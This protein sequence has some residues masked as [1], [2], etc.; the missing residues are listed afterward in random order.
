MLTPALDFLTA[1]E[2][3]PAELVEHA[4]RNDCHTIGLLVQ[5]VQRFPFPDGKL[6]G[7]TAERRQL[8]RTCRDLDVTIDTIEVFI[9]D[10]GCKP[11]LFRPAIETGAYLG[12]SA[13]NTLALDR[14]EARL[15]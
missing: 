11:N 15:A 5:P 3:S 4:A 9:L 7:D 12:A 8:Y 14:E 2:L 6:I 13:V 10:Q 1:L